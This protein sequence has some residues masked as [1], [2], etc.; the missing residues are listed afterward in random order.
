M[1]PEAVAGGGS[2]LTPARARSRVGRSAFGGLQVGSEHA[3]GHSGQRACRSKCI[4]NE[5]A[6]VTVTMLQY[7]TLRWVIIMRFSMQERVDLSPIYD[8]RLKYAKPSGR[9]KSREII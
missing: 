6:I 9:S 3:L 7:Y 1:L 2:R 5:V 8:R 4:V